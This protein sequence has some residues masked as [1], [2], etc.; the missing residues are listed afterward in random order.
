M[1]SWSDTEW[2][3]TSN[4]DKVD[5]YLAIGKPVSGATT[6]VKA[7]SKHLGLKMID[8][9]VLEELARKKLSPSEDEP[10][11]GP[12]PYL[13]VQ[14]EV[15]AIINKDKRDGKKNRYICDSIPQFCQGD[16]FIT[17]FMEA[18]GSTPMGM[19]QLKAEDA[20]IK[21]RLKKK[22]EVEELTEE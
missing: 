17:A 20:T 1:S 22:L 7:I 4:P 14:D 11:S 9:I 6:A 3:E 13:K 16:E 15:M 18:M 21:S 8:W 5:W 12:V 10:F 2:K 19:I